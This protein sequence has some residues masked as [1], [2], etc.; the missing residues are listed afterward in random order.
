MHSDA[1]GQLLIM[2]PLLMLVEYQVR[3][4]SAIQTLLLFTQDTWP[5]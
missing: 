2:V 3:K 5:C 1:K 4:K